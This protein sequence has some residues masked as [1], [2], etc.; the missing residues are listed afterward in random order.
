MTYKNKFQYFQ[1]DNEID[2]Y[3]SKNDKFKTNLIQFVVLNELN[4]ETVS[5]NALVPYIL[6]RGSKKYP[7][8]REFKIEMDKL[9][10]AELNVSVWKRGEIQVLNFSL[11]IV[12]EKY[13]PTDEPLLEEGLDLLKELV[14]NPL[15]TE[16]FFK[17]EREYIIKEIKSLINDKYSYSLARCYQ[18]M[19]EKEPYSIHKLGQIEK[20]QSMKYDFVKT[21]YEEIIQNHKILLFI[22][23]DIEYDDVFESIN[24][25]FQFDHQQ[26]ENVNK[27]IINKDIKEIKEVEEGLNVQQGKLVLGY[28]TNI[29][30]SNDLYY[31]LIVYNGILGTF[32]HSKLFQNVREKESLAYYASSSVESTKGLLMITSG[33]EFDAYEAAR[34]LILEQVDNLNK[35]LFSDDEFNWTK[36]SLIS[37]FKS[38]ADNIKA[39]VGHY[40]LGLINDHPETIYDS[41]QQIEKVSKNDIIEIGKNI[42]LDTVYFLNKKVEK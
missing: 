24:N 17:Q 25:K 5:Q 23:G 34:N 9:Y 20:H 33:I 32:P 41:I 11:E 14:L 15:F 13:L 26:P 3:L 12:N 37:R 38:S 21:Q 7:S 40:L 2:L 18:N 30:R 28:R 1:T 22:V 10:G 42:K 4:R 27:T 36:D 19:C 6:Y 35:G 29:T 16:K 31:S 8:S 39:I